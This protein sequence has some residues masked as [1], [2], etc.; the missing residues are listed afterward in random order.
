MKPASIALWGTI[1]LSLVGVLGDFLLKLA[2][3]K[4]INWALFLTGLLVYASTAIGW[5]FV[6][7]YIKLPTLGVF[8]AVTTILALTLISVFYFK[9]TL[10]G[11]EILGIGSA[12]LSLILLARFG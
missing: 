3:E 2:G 9:E 4:G 1:G 5:F 12:L 11:Y 8:Y 6:L 10:N 7:R